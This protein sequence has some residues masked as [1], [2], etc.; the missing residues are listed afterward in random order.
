LDRP[1][2][3]DQLHLDLWWHGMN[4]GK[5]AGTYLYNAPPPWDNAFAHTA[6]H[7]TLTIE[8]SIIRDQMT[9]VGRFLFLDWAQADIVAKKINLYGER[10]SLFVEHDGYRHLGVLHQRGVKVR[11]N[12]S[13]LV[14]DQVIP[15]KAKY[16]HSG[17]TYQAA[18]HWLLPDLPWSLDASDN[19]PESSSFRLGL[20]TPMG[21]ITLSISSEQ[22][23]EKASMITELQIIRAGK[24]IK[25]QGQINPTWGWS[26]PTY[27]VKIPALS[28][29]VVVSS[30]LP[31]QFRSEWTFP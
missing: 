25:G 20:E 21:V 13:W 31:I 23:S 8:P 6:I 24:I 4:I 12:N 19:T 26:S 27:G 10:E 2:H 5:D 3:A 1:G 30:G 15:I 18:L 16:A 7:N 22:P 28:I 14:E 29:R 9:Q 17:K 11:P